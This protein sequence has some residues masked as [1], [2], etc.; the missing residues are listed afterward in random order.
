[1][2]QT[3]PGPPPRPPSGPPAD[4]RQ[5][6]IHGVHLHRTDENVREIAAFAD[7]T[8]AAV[9]LDGVLDDLNRQGRESRGYFGRAVS[10]AFTW[11]AED[12]ATG[13]WYPQGITTSADA[14]DTEDIAG[15]RI[16]ATT[17]YSKQPD[18][19]HQ[20]ARISF[21]DLDLLRYR[22]VLLVVPRLTDEGR[23]ELSPL[24]VHAGGIVW[25]GPYLHIAATARGFMT[26]RV[27]DIIRIPDTVAVRDARRLAAEQGRVST[28]AYRYV[29]PVR[30]QYQGRA[31]DGY[32]KLRYSFLSLDRSA[33]PPELITGE[34]GGGELSTRL[35]HYR[36]DPRTQLPETLDQGGCRPATLEDHG[37]R[38]M[39]GIAF[40][41]GR[42]YA[43]VSHGP[44][45]PGSV[46]TG[47]P[48]DFRGHHLAMPF[49]PEDISYWPSTDQ[50]WSLS[51]FPRRRWIFSM[52]RD[53]FD[54]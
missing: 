26:C 9:G 8:G 34:Y 51:E 13:R 50:L 33:D 18:G 28:Y 16:L 32:P 20:G 6:S 1:M 39:Q 2:S 43:S 24:K 45:L 35:A 5:P 4:P 3:P 19:I 46:Y 44:F 22:H 29:L 53:W 49:G 15:R 40:V 27:D 21:W 36:L 41:R 11:D 47:R 38:R 37:V 17:W 14:S 23:L 30:F 48:G 42:Y 54:P 12:R 10:R 25:L 31:D 7:L 52:R